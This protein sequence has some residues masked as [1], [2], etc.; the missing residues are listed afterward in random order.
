MACGG[1]VAT[2]LSQ[3]IWQPKDEPEVGHSDGYISGIR[4]RAVYHAGSGW[5]VQIW[6]C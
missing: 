3:I 1:Y 5:D 6:A 4:F 2:T